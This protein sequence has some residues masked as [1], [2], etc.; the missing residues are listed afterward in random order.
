MAFQDK[1]AQKNWLEVLS[2]E[3]ENYNSS[4]MARESDSLTMFPEFTEPPISKSIPDERRVGSGSGW[5]RENP[6]LGALNK[7]TGKAA[8]ESKISGPNQVASKV[9]QPTASPISA[10][11]TP[12]TI[13]LL[14]KDFW[15]RDENV[16][17]CFLC[18]EPFSVFRR[19]HHCRLCGQI[20]DSKCT[21]MM[22]G[23]VFGKSGTIRVCKT[24]ET[25]VNGRDDSSEFS[26]SAASPV[27]IHD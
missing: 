26:D 8:V 4:S 5:F 10:T 23:N 14:S 6:F 7:S 13:K 18:G 27:D 3:P 20:Y 22:Q 12:A 11:V 1:R 25:I 19:K 17:D 24:C 15:M 2:S 9:D 16:K 21:T